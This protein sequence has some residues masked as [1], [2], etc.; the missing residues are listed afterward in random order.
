MKFNI[1]HNIEKEKIT[2][3]L[4]NILNSNAI[5]ITDSKIHNFSVLSTKE[6]DSIGSERK[7]QRIIDEFKIEGFQSFNKYTKIN[8][9]SIQI[10][11]SEIQSKLSSYSK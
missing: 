2:H 8:P 5:K 3:Q 1:K 10:T 6:E 11:E 9:I 4:Q 7:M